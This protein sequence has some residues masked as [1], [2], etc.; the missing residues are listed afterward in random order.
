MS[1][2]KT[3]G[4]NKISKAENT[5]KQWFLSNMDMFFIVLLWLAGMIIRILVLDYETQDMRGFF[6][7]W[8]EQIKEGGGLAALR[9]PLGNYSGA[10]CFFLALSTYLPFEPIVSIKVVS[11]VLD[12][13]LAIGV[14]GLV[15]ELSKD[16]KKGV[17]AASI[18]W[19]LPTVILNSAMWGQ[20]DGIYTAFLVLCAW[21]VVKRRYV[22]AFIMFGVALGFKLQA[23]FWIPVLLVLWFVDEKAHIW[24]YLLAG[25]SFLGTLLPCA[26]AGRSFKSQIK[27]Y[28]FQM[29][30]NSVLSLNMPNI[31]ALLGKSDAIE[32][33][34]KMI[35]RVGIV[36]TLVLL[37]TLCYY[38]LKNRK[39]LN[40]KL[41]L[42]AMMLSVL[43]INFFLP[44]MHERY[45]YSAVC[46]A[47]VLAFFAK[48]YVFV[49][50]AI[51]THAFFACCAP[52]LYSWN[53]DFRWLALVFG[54]TILYVIYDLRANL[55]A[56]M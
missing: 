4:E 13:V 30:D 29:E 39:Q 44:H 24:H 33:N 55:K 40:A 27:T 25:L 12:V 8:Y 10:S 19:L 7:V 9:E 37:G 11:I 28:L 34:V 18:T 21:F 38:L 49:F 41:W 45:T 53:V 56:S 31:Y 20:A 16:K 32:A 22:P 47:L 17:L 51:F 26:L 52:L 14:G 35:E 5:I 15:Y 48:K 43:I 46:L 1:V 23:V 42:E 36:M 50:L 2:Q 54:G 3:Q 6:L